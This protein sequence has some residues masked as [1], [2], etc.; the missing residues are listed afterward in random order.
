MHFDR[1]AALLHI[2]EKT[3]QFPQLRNIH[4][5]AM[6]E[7]Q[8]EHNKEAG[9]FLAEQRAKAEEKRQAD[10]EEKQAAYKREQAELERQNRFTQVEVPDEPTRMPGEP[11]GVAGIKRRALDEPAAVDVNAGVTGE[12]RSE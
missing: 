6:H 5:A 3:V 2:A 10:E 11:E 9:E 1:I 8:E 12:G 4:N 7:L